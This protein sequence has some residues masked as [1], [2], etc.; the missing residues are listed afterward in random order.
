MDERYDRD[1]SKDEGTRPTGQGLR[2]VAVFAIRGG[3]VQFDEDRVVRLNKERI[4]IG[5]VV[6]ADVRLPGTGV[7]PIHAVLELYA[8][9]KDPDAPAT[10][11]DLASGGGTFVDS[12]KVVTQTLKGGET[13]KIGPHEIKFSIEDVSR[14]STREQI[15]S[16]EGRALF[17]NPHEDFSQLLLTDDR[18]VEEI[19]DYRPTSKRALEVVM[20]WRG[21]I[22]NVEHFVSDRSVTVGTTRRSD[23]GIPPVLSMG[24]YP[25]VTRSGTTFTLNLDTQMKGV[26]HRKGRLSSL[27]EVRDAATRGPYGYQVIIEKDDFAKLTLGEVDFYLSFTSAPPRLKRQKI[28]DRDPFFMKIM[29]SSLLA[30][31]VLIVALLKVKVPPQLQT[32]E[33]PQRI[34][35]I[36]YQP[37]KYVSPPKPIEKV[38]VSEAQVPQ[39]V[40]PIKPKNPPKPPEP[41]IPPKKPVEIKPS[42]T[43]LDFEKSHPHTKPNAGAKASDQNQ[44]KGSSVSQNEGHE[45]AGARAKGTEGTR[46]SK[47]SHNEGEHQTHANRPSPQGGKGAGGS[48]SQVPGEGTLDVLKGM[49]NNIKNLLESS[50]QKLGPGGEKLGGF[51]GFDTKGGGG[52]ALSGNGRGGG[53]NAES[54]GGLSDHGK[55]GGR[56]GTGLG[57][58]GEGNGIVG[59]KTRVI[60]RTGGPEETVVMGAIDAD[61][62]EKAILAHK[63]EF[64]YCYE[65]EINA[66]Q[67]GISGR[68]GTS[69]VIGGRGTV[70]DAGVVS[71]SLGNANAEKCII[72]VLTRIQFPEP[73]GGGTVT[74][75]YPFKF[76]PQGGG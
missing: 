9:P 7:E 20:S 72:K 70:L 11:F 63:D 29:G 41:V 22:L 18:E 4:V 73:R 45:G 53:G 1:G 76:R 47:T 68:V 6:S 40:R 3:A 12:R 39:P 46:G 37:E 66:G 5:S 42:H 32:E 44:H 56:V 19:F 8:S 33:I 71:S 74:V 15:R 60:L 31:L 61:E 67:P 35:T 30:T 54:L 10:I 51:G 69:F 23:F 43:T 48:H 28:L 27:N 13:I 25:I 59:G 49:S 64:R 34:A 58:A 38:H 57:A 24:N 26:M 52:L 50:G 62:V 2:K 14:Y 55:G 21:V 75:K 65:R 17:L 36:L 16:S